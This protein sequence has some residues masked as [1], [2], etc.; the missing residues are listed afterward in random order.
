VSDSSGDWWDEPD[1]PATPYESPSESLPEWSSWSSWS[2]PPWYTW[3]TLGVLILLSAPAFYVGD[4]PGLLILFGGSAAVTG[5]YSLFRNRMSWALLGS[6]VFRVGV[7]VFGSLAVVCAGVMLAAAGGPTDGEATSGTGAPVPIGSGS[8]IA[9]ASPSAQ[10]SL[11]SSASPVPS[12]SVDALGPL[13]SDLLAE[14]DVKG[15]APKTG[16][17]RDGQFGDPWIDVDANGCDTRNDVLA[18]DLSAAVLDDDLCTVRSGVFAD[19]YTGTTM[20]FQRGRDSMLVQIDHIVALN[21]AWQ[22]GAQ[23]LTLEQRISFANDPLNLMASDG[24]QNQKKGAGD[25][26]TWLP[27][28]KSFRCA[29]VARQVTVKA[30]YGLWV[31]PPEHAAIARVLSSCPEQRA[32]SR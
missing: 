12:P 24:T 13:A 23:Q 21:N 20:D 9:S 18:R 28:N 17:D 5:S 1:S 11:S 14:L 29:Y 10:P 25:A 7:T 19:P 4:V 26:A 15:R 6:R 32:I 22:T 27:P 2:R 8:P 31:T 3:V 16:Y 30:F